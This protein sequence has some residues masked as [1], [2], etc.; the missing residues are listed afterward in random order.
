MGGGYLILILSA[1]LTFLALLA[2]GVSTV[3]EF[4]GITEVRAMAEPGLREILLLALGAVA[5][6]VMLLSRRRYL[7]LG[8]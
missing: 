2:A 8:H 7:T 3:E 1:A 5:G 6:M 4:V